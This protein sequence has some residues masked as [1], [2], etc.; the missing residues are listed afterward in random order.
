MNIGFLITVKGSII[1]ISNNSFFTNIA[2]AINQSINLFQLTII[3]QYWISTFYIHC[4]SWHVLG[5]Y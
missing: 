5:H 4:I 3:I 2:I 1:V